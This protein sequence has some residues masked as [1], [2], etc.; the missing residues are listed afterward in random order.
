[1]V[2]RLAGVTDADAPEQLSAGTSKMPWV[3]FGRSLER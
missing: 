3:R 1:M 2:V